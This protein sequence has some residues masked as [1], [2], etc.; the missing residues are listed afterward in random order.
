MA[1]KTVVLR[2]NSVLVPP[3]VSQ[4][5]MHFLKA[6]GDKKRATNR[7]GSDRDNRV[8]SGAIRVITTGTSYNSGRDN[9]S[10]NKGRDNTSYNND[11]DNIVTTVTG[12]TRAVTMAGAT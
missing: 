8:I 9:T 4:N 2:E 7:V 12:T 6:L 3:C 1:G 5:F 11:R 10:C